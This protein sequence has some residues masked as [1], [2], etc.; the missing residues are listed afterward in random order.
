[1][2]PA[3]QSRR[4]LGTSNPALL[5]SV[6]L[7]DTAADDLRAFCARDDLLSALEH[8]RPGPVAH[9]GGATEYIRNGGLPNV[10]IEKSF[11]GNFAEHVRNRIEGTSI[12]PDPHD[13]IID[14]FG[15]EHQRIQDFAGNSPIATFVHNKL[16][17]DPAD[18][19]RT[20]DQYYDRLQH[21][22]GKFEDT[23]QR[24]MHQ[25]VPDSDKIGIHTSTDSWQKMAEHSRDYV[26]HPLT[27][28]AIDI[29][30]H[31]AEAI[32]IYSVYFLTMDYAFS[33]QFDTNSLYKLGGS[34]P[35][36]VFRYTAIT[37]FEAL[38]FEG[39]GHFTGE[40]F[41]NLHQH[42][43]IPGLGLVFIQGLNLTKVARRKMEWY[44]FRRSLIS[45]SATTLTFL[46]CSSMGSAAAAS[47]GAGT[48]VCP[49]IGTAVGFVA[50]GAVSGL[51]I[52]YN[53][54]RTVRYQDNR[55]VAILE[56]QKR[57]YQPLPNVLQ[58]ALSS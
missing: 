57:L 34:L 39:I 44:Q 50:G 18:I 58:P 29:T 36:Y 12:N 1:M 51:F 26:Q 16:E 11:F 4:T 8:T 56:T 23:V 21:Y 37:G 5:S 33:G 38:G 7:F 30:T 13:P 45:G 2:K 40:A 53:H 27:Q 52:Y 22:H 6:G 14:R 42:L 55:I 17:D 43:I 46:A 15:P 10:Q 28:G 54:R 3:W 9:I 47:A 32:V 41:T 19:H 48:A 35:S 49:V 20:T 25:I 31:E 24:H